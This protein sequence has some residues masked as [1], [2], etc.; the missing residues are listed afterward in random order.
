MK[1][2]NEKQINTIILLTITLLT[3]CLSDTVKP[4][5]LLNYTPKIT[6]NT[7]FDNIWVAGMP[8]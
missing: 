3:S 5:I 4:D 7:D 8:V 2:M 1:R 6:V